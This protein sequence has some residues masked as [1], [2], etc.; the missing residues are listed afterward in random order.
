M[1]RHSIWASVFILAALLLGPK[2]AQA[3]GFLDFAVGG[4][5]TQDHKVDVKSAGI[6]VNFDGNFQ[7]SWATGIRGGYWFEAV[8]WLGVGG[9]VSYFEP[10]IE[11]NGATSG[12]EVDLGVAPVSALLMLRAPLVVDET[13]PHGR[14][15][16]YLNVGPGA[17]V[18]VVDDHHDDDESSV[19]AGVDLHAGATFLITSRFGMFAE[20]RFT[21]FD[22]DIDYEHH[23]HRD[24]GDT[25]I[26]TTLDT[27]HVMVGFA[28]HFD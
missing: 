11:A 14:F 22:A 25:E 5:F 9:M 2:S 8:P 19:D 6:E 13:F 27:H 24:Y 10:D 20:Y 16:P 21:H 4:S 15:Q 23:H 7:D 28:W 12:N 17:F 3:E 26:D 18:S 1:A